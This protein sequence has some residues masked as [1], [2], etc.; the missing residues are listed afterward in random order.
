MKRF[1]LVY[2][3]P[4]TIAPMVRL[5]RSWELRSLFIRNLPAGTRFV[6]VPAR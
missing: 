2:H 4:D 3:V 1:K 5:F 6:A